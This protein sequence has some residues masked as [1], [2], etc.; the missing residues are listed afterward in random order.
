MGTL[1]QEQQE[2]L[3]Y[4]IENGREVATMVYHV[5][6]CVGSTPLLRVRDAA[7]NTPGIPQE[8]SEILPRLV[9]ESVEA[10]PFGQDEATVTVTARTPEN[11]TVIG[12]PGG[13][14]NTFY[15][16]GTTLEQGVTNF[17][18]TQLSKPFS[19]RVPA[20]VQYARTIGTGST[21]YTTTDEQMITLPIYLPRSTWVQRKRIKTTADRVSQ[22]S[23]KYAGKVNS[24]GWRGGPRNAWLCTGIVGTSQDLVQWDIVETFAFD[25]IDF[26]RP[27]A[28]YVDPLTGQTPA[29]TQDD[30]AQLNG[31]AQVDVQPE[32]DFNG[33]SYG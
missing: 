5:T 3:K 22:T 8:G 13:S 17:D 19:A 32:A 16:V 11:Q 14:L 29:L 20:T 26:W 28:R 1:L 27:T 23:R 15:E 4:R 24:A 30:V 25:D 18:R 10:V 33:I 9:V 31:I 6:G 2:G 7:R 21:A 12:V